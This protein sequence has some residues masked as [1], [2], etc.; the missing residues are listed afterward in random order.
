MK[1]SNHPATGCCT[2]A[3]M[4]TRPVDVSWT[5]SATLVPSAMSSACS[6]TSCHTKT[7][8]FPCE[9]DTTWPLSTSVFI[10]SSKKQSAA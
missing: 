6:S 3:G 7:S 4:S 2:L 8:C 5:I 1:P 9:G 10:A